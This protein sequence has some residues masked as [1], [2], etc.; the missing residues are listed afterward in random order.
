MFEE[1][2]ADEQ[3]VAEWNRLAETVVRELRLAGFTATPG[4]GRDA[5]PGAQVVVDPLGDGGGG[6]FVSWHRDPALTRDVLEKMTH[7]E[8]VRQMPEVRHSGVIA[9]EMHRA[10]LAILNSAGFTATDGS[11]DMDPF[12][13]RV[14]PGGK[15]AAVP[16]S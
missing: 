9:A 14:E 1:L 11:T 12:T 3:S 13:I 16:C 15:D 7:G 2:R 10:M 4:P 5:V 8:D 6:V